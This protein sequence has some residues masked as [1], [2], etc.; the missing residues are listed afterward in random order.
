LPLLT[1]ERLVDVD[2]L[3]GS[4]TICSLFQFL[5]CFR[6]GHHTDLMESQLFDFIQVLQN[7]H[8]DRIQ[9]GIES[10]GENDCLISTAV[11]VE[12]IKV[13]F[14]R[15]RLLLLLLVELYKV[16][17]AIHFEVN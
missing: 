7:Y 9:E 17:Y 11:S 8:L 5:A 4:G 12:K 16:V 3:D 10:F 14:E 15:L 6:I 1:Q 2:S 13:V